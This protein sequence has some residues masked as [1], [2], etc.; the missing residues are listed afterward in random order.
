VSKTVSSLTFKSDINLRMP[1]VEAG[2]IYELIK[3]IALT[4][5][6]KI[7]IE[8]MGSYRRGKAD[9]GDIDILISRDPSDGVT[10][11]GEILGS[12]TYLSLY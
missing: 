9:C 4:I 5:D 3:L 7:F 2:Q 8:I 11:A 10:H 6:P 12:Q 1:R